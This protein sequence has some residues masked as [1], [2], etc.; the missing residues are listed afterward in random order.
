MHLFR[1]LVNSPKISHYFLAL[2]AEAAEEDPEQPMGELVRTVY[3]EVYR[4]FLDDEQLV[5]VCSRLSAHG[6][7]V[8]DQVDAAEKPAGNGKPARTTGSSDRG[9]G[10]Y[11]QE[12]TAK[13]EMPQLCLL[14][15]NFD[16]D[17]ARQLYLL[18][19]YEVVETMASCWRGL[20]YER[21]RLVYEASL[22]GFGG[23]YGK[24]KGARRD[25]GEVTVHD[26]SQLS[27]DAVRSKIAALG[28]RT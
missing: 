7:R 16:A 23:K 19:D 12:W 17:R 1:R 14:L 8:I 3:A 22:F 6:Q 11:F 24:D 27:P 13:L 15:A 10:E 28:K 18:E 26:L 25:E 5:E 4:K 20:E 21:G 9:F 2:Y